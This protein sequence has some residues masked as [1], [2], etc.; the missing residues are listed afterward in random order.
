MRFKIEQV[1]VSALLPV[2]ATDQFLAK[3]SL[4]K[5]KKKNMGEEEDAVKNEGE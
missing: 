5:K 2:N 1:P 4:A 3:Q